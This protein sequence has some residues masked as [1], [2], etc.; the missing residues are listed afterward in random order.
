MNPKTLKPAEN[1]LLSVSILANNC[2]DA[3]A[4][5]TACMS[6]GL[7]KSKQFI[8]TNN[9]DACFIYVDKDDTLTFLLMNVKVNIT[10]IS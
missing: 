2:M 9:I 10:R 1:N 6:M 3:D 8:S 7:N 5:A 4:Y